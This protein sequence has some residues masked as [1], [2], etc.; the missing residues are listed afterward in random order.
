MEGRRILH[1]VIGPGEPPE[2]AFPPPGDTV[3]LLDPHPAPAAGRR[4]SPPGEDRRR[5]PEEILDLVLSH[6]LVVTW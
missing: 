4:P 6:D 3:V 5:D 1:L 2:L